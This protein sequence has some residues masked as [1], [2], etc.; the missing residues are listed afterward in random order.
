MSKAGSTRSSDLRLAGKTAIEFR[1]PDASRDARTSCN[2]NESSLSPAKLF[3]GWTS[4]TTALPI[5]AQFDSGVIELHLPVFP[6]RVSARPSGHALKRSLD[7][8]GSLLGLLFVGPLMIMVALLI[9]ALDGGPAIF[10][11][12]RI[13]FGG[14][15]FRILKFRTMDTKANGA[16]AA[17]LATNSSQRIEWATRQKLARDPRITPLGRLLRIS[18]IDELPQLINVLKGDMS[19]VGPRPIVDSECSRYGRY[20]DRYCSVRP[21]ITGLW[22][23][24]GRNDTTYRRRVAIDVTYSRNVGLGLDLRI[25]LLTVPALFAGKGCY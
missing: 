17:L 19:L 14:R 5:P 25:L 13:G 15:K 22:Q 3:A 9:R 10:A 2:P 23:V 8:V 1:S 24:S 18:S 11:Q 16:L 4:G 7:I 6:E 21:G 20:F 12:E